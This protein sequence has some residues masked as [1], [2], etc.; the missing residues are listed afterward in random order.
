MSATGYKIKSFSLKAK[1]KIRNWLFIVLCSSMTVQGQ[2]ITDNSG[3]KKKSFKTGTSI[4]R[5]K[6]SAYLFTY[7]TGNGKGEEAICF[8]LSNDGYNFR[9]LNN[10]MP[11]ISSLQISSTGG[12]RDPHILR[13]ADGKTFYMVATDMCVA[14]NGWNAN[15]AMVFMKSQDL[16]NWSSHVIN[17]PQLFPEFA[18]VNRVWAPQTIYD[19][20]KG[21]YMVY[22]SMRKGNEPDKIYYAYANSDFTGLETTP[23]QLFHHPEN[24]PCIDGDIIFKGGKYYLFFKDGGKNDGIKQAVSGK[25]T[26]G[27][28]LKDKRMEQTNEDVEGA[29]V[30]KLNNSNSW[31]LMYDVYRIGKYQFT[32]SKDLENFKLIDKE[33]SMNFQ[34]RHGT[35]I[36]VTAKEAE[37]LVSKWLTSED[38]MLSAHSNA[39]K[40]LN[41]A[42]DTADKKVNLSVKP[43]TGLGSFNPEFILFPGVTVQPQGSQNFT[44]DRVK[45]SVAIK[46][47]DVQ[48]FDVSVKENH[49]PVLDGYYADPEIL[50]AEKTGKFYIY[51]TSDGFTNWTGTYFK[52]FSSANLVDWKDEGVI[53]DLAKD[54]SWA[55]K[56]A[57]A[58]CIIEKKMDGRYK[59]FYYF[60]AAQ[61]VGVAVA[62]NPTGPFVDS[63][64]PLIEKYPEG[65]K[66]GQQIDP[67]VFTD[68]KTGKSYLY[69]GNGYMAGAELNEDMVSVKPGSTKVITP[70]KNF[71]EGTYVIYRKGVYY[72]MWSVDDT[73]SENYQVRYG[74]ADSPLGKIS[75]PENNLVIIKDKESGI[76]A[77]GHNSVVQIPGTDEWYLVYHRFNYPNGLAMGRA[78]GYNR[79]VCI[80]KLEFNTDGSIKQVK[81]TH[82]GIQ[83][84]DIKR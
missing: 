41:I 57:W 19:P 26:E 75:I 31:I 6:T 43:G 56:N 8:A 12:V 14:K 22:W 63:G 33:I 13:G 36:P 2:Q 27:Y 9:A 79:E 69:W 50:F 10:N 61:K 11:V 77:T 4:Q 28:N 55:K 29:G 60:T 42:L 49:N 59:Y 17:I 70:D 45:Y 39:L 64:K 82:A 18:G 16:V 58:P 30:F 84:V 68:P 5:A 67:D 15:H 21:R 7:F 23:K 81:P 35:V 78:A 51:P 72:F 71:R 37:I 40:K 65:V 38:V 53:L 62:D 66:G 73:R 83:A 80:D 47:R 46:G 48:T 34:P 52:T 74:T 76:Y 20:Q 25:L 32:R 54:V 24:V 1:K 3:S 44:S